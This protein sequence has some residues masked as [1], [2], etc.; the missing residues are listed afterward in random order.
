MGRRS[1]Y[2]A[3]KR[4]REREKQRKRKDKAERR[5]RRKLGEGAPEEPTEDGADKAEEPQGERRDES[6]AD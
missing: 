5:K 4:Q 1:E 6:P 3:G 2:S